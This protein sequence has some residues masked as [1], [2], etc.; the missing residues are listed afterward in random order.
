MLDCL[1]VDGRSGGGERAEI[2]AL[3]RGEGVG[4][5]LP[6]GNAVA[7]AERVLV[8]VDRLCAVSPVVVVDDVQWADEVSVSVWHRLAGATAQVPLLLVA[9]CRPVPVSAGLS[10]PDIA[11]RL[12]LSRNTVQSH[13]SRVLAKLQAR[14][15]V[16]VAMAA[17]ARQRGAEDPVA[18]V[19]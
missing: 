8:L 7:A 6:G 12:F 11:A 17:A 18:P 14:S 19:R 4:G 10:N 1:G 13:M 15:R 9:V 2:A 5:L 3:L 16:E